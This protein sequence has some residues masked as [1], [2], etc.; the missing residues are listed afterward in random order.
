MSW[1][2]A[3]SNDGSFWDLIDRPSIG[4][5]IERFERKQH[6]GLRLATLH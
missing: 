3:V 1:E 6:L 2:I 5:R 4:E